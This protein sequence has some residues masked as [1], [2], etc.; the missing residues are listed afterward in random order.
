MSG[1]SMDGCDAVLVEISQPTSQ[2]RPLIVTKSF[3][4]HP[5]SDQLRVQIKKQLDPNSSRIDELT[6]LDAAL[7]IWFIEA[8]DALLAHAGLSRQDIDLIGSHGQTMWHDV[9]TADNPM[10]WQLSDGSFIAAVTGVTTVCDFRTAD[11]AV[12][13][14]GA[15]L[16]P[17]FDQLMYGGGDINIALQNI[18]G[19]GN[20]TL[21]PSKSTL[22]ARAKGTATLGFDTGPGNML[23]DRFVEKLTNGAQRYDCGGQMAAKGVVCEDLLEQWLAHPFFSQQ[24]PKSTGREQFGHAYAD[25]R[26]AAALSRGLSAEDAVATV[27]ALT[28]RTISMAYQVAFNQPGLE[29]KDSNIIGTATSSLFPD[30]VIVA[31]GGA[32]NVT[33]MN[34]LETLLA[35]A[36]VVRA[37]AEKLSAE[38]SGHSDIESDSKEAVAFAL[39]AYLAAL[40]QSN[41][42]PVTTGASKQVIL[43]KIC[44][45]ENYQR[46]LLAARNNNYYNN[47]NN[48]NNNI[49]TSSSRLPQAVKATSIPASDGDKLIAGISVTETRNASS[50]RIDTLSAQDVVKLMNSED[51]HVFRVVAELRAVIASVAEN[52]AACIA[53]GGHV[54]YVGAGSS[55]RLGVLDASE[56]PPTFSAPAAWFTGVIAG[57]DTALRHAVEGAEDHPEY[58]KRDILDRGVCGVDIVIG[59]AASG[60]TPYVHGALQAAKESAQCAT[61]LITCNPHPVRESYVDTVIAAVVGPELITGSTRLKAGTAT[62]LILNQLSTTAMILS[63]KTY[64]NLMVDVKVSNA[65]LRRRAIGII[66]TIA[67]SKVDSGDNDDSECSEMLS[68]REAEALLDD[69]GGQVKV[70]VAMHMAGLSKV[71]AEEALRCCQGRLSSVISRQ[72]NNS[73][74]SFL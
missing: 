62:K 73:L 13:G 67:A 3:I 45:G 19:I 24:P 12:G 38:D 21:V 50:M 26:L 40:G 30:K 46:V 8:V 68:E 43:G 9:N 35:P 69:A 10:T 34:M 63:G 6:K 64:G 4:T 42:L 51:E 7:S 33:L 29:V 2:T 22:A 70:A 23:I 31:G 15:P 48:Y 28:A 14:Q 36:V 41:H 60:K 52:I 16:I 25:E 32:R 37:G 11:V 20:V 44:P 1:T 55:G 54:F 53:A 49:N 57:G 56:I 27:T 47:Y 58:G 65:K 66:R 59:V 17:F 74:A 5:M 61:V 72:V 71:D 18:G 39:F